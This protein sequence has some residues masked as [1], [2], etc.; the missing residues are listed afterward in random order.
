MLGIVILNYNTWEV[1][2]KCVQSIMETCL[3]KH[4]I[5]IV[6]NHSNNDSYDILVERYRSNFNILVIKSDFNGGY[7]KGNNIGI[8][9]GI[10]DGCEYMIITNNDI[11]FCNNCIQELFDFIYS[12]SKAVIVG[13]KIFKLNGEIQHSSIIKENT[14]LEYLG[15]RRNFNLF[16]IDEANITEATKVYA[17]SG[18]CF[19]ISSKKFFEIGA[20]DEGTFLYNEESI[21][22]FQINNSKYETYFLPTAKVVHNH[23]ATTG[24]QSLFINGEFLKSGLYYWRKYRKINML[25]LILIWINFTSRTLIKSVYSVDLRDEMGKYLKETWKTLWEVVKND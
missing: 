8:R 15:F 13:P 19:I 1:T 4:K 11:I 5:Y 2:I 18:C 21:L 20:F 22:S 17:I 14:Y 9:V 6:D 7:A 25:Q 12:S 24:K 16:T 23:G 3:I 10:Q